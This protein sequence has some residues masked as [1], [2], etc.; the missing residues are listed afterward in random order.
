MRL[1]SADADADTDADTDT[2]STTAS[3]TIGAT[4]GTL[5]G[6]GATL[7]VPPGALSADLELVVSWGAAD[8]QLPDLASIAADVYDFGPDGTTFDPAG[9]LSLP[10]RGQPGTDQRVVVS[11]LDGDTWVDLPTSVNGQ[12]ATASVGHF[13]VFTVRFGERVAGQCDP[14]APCGGDVVGDWN[15]AAVCSLEPT[16]N[17]FAA[18]CPSAPPATLYLTP[19]GTVSFA[20]GGTY[21]VD[22]TFDVTVGF[23]IPAECRKLPCGLLGCTD[24][25]NDGCDCAMGPISDR[26]V[27]TGTW[28]ADGTTLTLRPDGGSP[29]VVDYCVAGDT[30]WTSD[31]AGTVVSLER[32]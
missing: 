26:S 12:T 6:G 17:P 13:T 24:D 28:T 29:D 14:V 2:S 11:W 32:L 22:V 10:F 8:A 23:S 25:G 19:N 9:M 31:A 7:V 3:A 16:E 27:E 5:A 20:A 30:A 1:G 21:D 4:G 18:D 15:Y